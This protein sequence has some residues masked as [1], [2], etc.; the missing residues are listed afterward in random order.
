MKYSLGV[1]IG[2]TNIRMAV[3]SE[4]GEIVKVIKKRT[5]PTK[6]ADDLVAQILELYTEIGAS[7]YDVVGMGIGVPGPV[8]Q[9]TGFTYVLSNLG[10][11]DFNLKEMLEPKLKI[12]VIV[13]NDANLAAYAEATLGEGKGKKIVQFITVS[14]GVGGGLIVNGEVI[15]GK[16]GFAQEIGNMIVDQN[17]TKKQNESMANGSFESLCSGTAL[18]ASAKEEGLSVE[19]AGQLF[20]LASQGNEKALKIKKTW[21]KNM[22]IALANMVAYMEP[23]VFILGG[24]VM[25]SKQYFLDELKKEIDISVFPQIRGKIDIQPAKFDQDA[26]IIGAALICFGK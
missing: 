18:V 23:D 25:L 14:T 5:R 12:N 20:E 26:G 24:G 7:S 21:L 9:E 8:I 10:I 19:H 3:V 13:G 11:Y 16:L 22:G 4:T 6:T 17:S 1:D 2:G 15:S